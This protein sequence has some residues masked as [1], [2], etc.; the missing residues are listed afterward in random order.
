MCLKERDDRHTYA[1]LDF[2]VHLADARRDEH[3]AAVLDVAASTQRTLS[4]SPHQTRESTAAN[5]SNLL[6]GLRKS[7]GSLGALVAPISRACAS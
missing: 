5:N 3:T 7:T 4:R 2:V 1:Q 6:V